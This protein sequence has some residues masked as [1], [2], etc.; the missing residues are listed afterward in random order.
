M[1]ESR[2]FAYHITDVCERA[3]S[4][5]HRI[6]SLGKERFNL[7]DNSLC[8]CGEEG[9]PEH[10]VLKCPRYEDLENLRGRIRGKNLREMIEYQDTYN[11]LNTLAQK[12][13]PHQQ[14]ED[15]KKQ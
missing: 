9:T 1:D 8:E 15:R 12:V 7:K 13:S 10:V 2:M 6:T 5:M 14:E 11:V 3:T 4:A